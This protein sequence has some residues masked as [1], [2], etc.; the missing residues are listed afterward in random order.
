RCD[1]GFQFGMTVC[2]SLRAPAINH[3]GAVSAVI[4]NT[5][6]GDWR[7]PSRPAQQVDEAAPASIKNR[8]AERHRMPPSSEGCLD[9][10]LAR[11]SEQ[12]RQDHRSALVISLSCRNGRQKLLKQ[13][14]IV[15]Q[16]V[17]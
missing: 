11:C 13:P 1:A 4:V 15:T 10:C 2:T 7:K 12:M 6:A 5:P 8:V 16:A 17:C 14:G 9:Q 3:S